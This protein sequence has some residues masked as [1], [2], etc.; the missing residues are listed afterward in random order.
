MSCPFASSGGPAPHPLPVHQEES[1]NEE[2]L[3][4]PQPPE[5]LFGLLGNLPDVEPAFP[6]RALWKLAELYGPIY[7]MN[8]RSPVVVVSNQQYINE[9]CDET[10]FEK[11]VA[12]VLQEVR[13][14]LG[15]GLFTADSQS[16]GWWKAHRVL[17]P[18]F[19]PIA[20][21]KMFPEMMDIASQMILRWDRQGP[22][23]AIDVADDFTRLG[24]LGIGN[25]S[26]A[27]SDF[28]V[29]FD[30]IGF[31]A[32]SY[33][34]NEFYSEN[35][36]PFAQQM[37]EV[38]LECGKRASRT[39]VENGL[40]IWSEAHRQENIKK[41]HALADEIVAERK[42]N[43]Q[44]D[45][46]DL[47]N[48]MLSTADP[49]TGEKLSDE[50]VRNNMVTFLVRAHVDWTARHVLTSVACRPRDHILDS[51][52]LLLQLDEEP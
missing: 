48:V 41:M 50:N 30:T 6:T 51:W 8:L 27:S 52:V 18:S 42:R 19:G 4:I 37:G 7:K 29:A 15:D 46:K 21:R 1:S 47:L 11:L 17:A 34:F 23:H 24:K 39:S 40:H 22:D 32:F 5:H 9:V 25:V 20:L 13:S 33:R 26:G 45:N 38:L 28:K 10:R 49:D 14:L 16:K 36:H 3:P 44:P 43:P 12:P 2:T 31:C 35:Q